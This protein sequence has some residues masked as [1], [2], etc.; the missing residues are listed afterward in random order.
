MTRIINNKEFTVRLR[1]TEITSDKVIAAIENEI[2]SLNN[3]LQ[4]LQLN[5]YNESNG[6]F[7]IP[8][9]DD[10]IYNLNI[11][12]DRLMKR[13]C[14]VKS[15]PGYTYTIHGYYDS[16]STN[17]IYVAVGDVYILDYV[18]IYNEATKKWEINEY[19]S[20]VEALEETIDNAI[21][22]YLFESTAFGKNIIDD[23]IRRYNSSIATINL[24]NYP[25]TTTI[26]CKDCGQYFVIGQEEADWFQLRSFE[27]PKRCSNCRSIRKRNRYDL[28][29][30]SYYQ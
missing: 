29:D 4:L 12:R 13:L 17:M 3:E 15:N 27:I 19:F 1:G 24:Y 25:T 22:G 28:R 2:T 9:K 23:N 11:R 5:Y 26:K 10:Q 18:I 16:I 7:G 8:Y 20:S 21:S 30:N 14:Y 6:K